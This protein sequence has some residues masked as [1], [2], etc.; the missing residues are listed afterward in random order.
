[1]FL[2]NAVELGLAGALLWAAALAMAVGG[3]VFRRGPPEVEPWRLGLLAFAACWFVV[4][5]FS[6]LGYTFSNYV[7]WIWAGMVGGAAVARPGSTV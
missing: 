2:S 3:A 5:N 4:S 7:L 1:V 6:P